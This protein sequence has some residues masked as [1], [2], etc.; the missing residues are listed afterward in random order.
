MSEASYQLIT[1]H[2]LDSFSESLD[3]S[4]IQTDCNVVTTAESKMEDVQLINEMI[5][6]G[7]RLLNDIDKDIEMLDEITSN[8]LK[9]YHDLVASAENLEPRETSQTLKNTYRSIFQQ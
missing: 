1:E 2:M 7:K 4:G 8:D 9:D 3:S 5:D 6:E